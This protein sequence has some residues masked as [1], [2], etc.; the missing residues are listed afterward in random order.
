MADATGL[1]PKKRQ[2][3]DAAV[4]ATMATIDEH[5]SRGK[6]IK[7]SMAKS[8]ETAGVLAVFIRILVVRE[9]PSLGRLPDIHL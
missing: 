2:R 7:H 4:L 1:R 9:H 5:I 6:S 3:I 8:K